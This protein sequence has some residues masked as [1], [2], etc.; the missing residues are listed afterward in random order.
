MAEPQHLNDASFPPLTL[1][2]WLRV[3]PIL[4]RLPLAIAVGVFRE[5][6]GRSWS[7]AANI[8]STRYLMSHNWDIHTMRSFIGLTTSQAYQKWALQDNQEILTDSLSEGAKLH[9][10]GPRRDTSQDRV[11]LYF[12]GGAFSF[13][14]RSSNFQFM[15]ALQKEVHAPLGDVG[16]ALLEYSLTPEYPIPTQLRQANAA[17]THLLNK[18]IS[19]AN[20]VI[21]G[22]SAGGNLVLQLA[23]HILHPLPSIPA[24]P[25]LAEP[26]AGAL[27]ISP[28]CSSSVDAPS[29]TRNNGKDILS[30]R[31][32]AFLGHYFEVLSVPP[33]WWNRL[34]GNEVSFDHV[35]EMSAVISQ[36]VRDTATMVGPGAVHDELLAKFATGEGGS[37]QEY[38][39]IIAFLS[40]SF[41]GGS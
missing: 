12:H 15:R 34:D 29:F 35:I 11:F 28:W 41:L 32:G 25:V 40:R 10:I 38:D 21:G 3:F 24:P 39:A 20:I 37:G 13:P 23:S 36:H 30:R 1:R 8:A 16:V 22:D 2:Q 27:L 33:A 7:L 17:L 6:K 26:L 9:W 31:T 14:A 19:P 18:G 4:A 5:N